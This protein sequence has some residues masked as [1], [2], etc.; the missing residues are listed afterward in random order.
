MDKPY[1]RIR[2]CKGKIWSQH[3]PIKLSYYKP[4][5]PD[6]FIIKYL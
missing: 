3:K 6:L 4:W 1:I 2:I 5:E